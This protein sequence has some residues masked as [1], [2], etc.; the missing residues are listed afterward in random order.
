MNIEINIDWNYLQIY[1]YD[2]PRSYK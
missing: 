2:L 1:D